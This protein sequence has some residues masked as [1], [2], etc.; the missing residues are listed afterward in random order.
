MSSSNDLQMLS[1]QIFLLWTLTCSILIGLECAMRWGPLC[2][3]RPRY[4]VAFQVVHLSCY[5]F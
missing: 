5:L 2:F 4:F 3:E 1:I